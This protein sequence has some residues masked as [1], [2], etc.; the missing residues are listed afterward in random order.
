MLG[1]KD[2]KAVKPVASNTNLQITT[3]AGDGD[4]EDAL[5]VQIGDHVL[6]KRLADNSAEVT[7]GGDLII[8]LKTGKGSIKVA[9]QDIPAQ[10]AQSL[11]DTEQITNST[12]AAD[13]FDDKGELGVDALPVVTTQADPALMSDNQLLSDERA[14]DTSQDEVLPVVTSTIVEADALADDLTANNDQLQSTTTE[15]TAISPAISASDIKAQ[16]QPRR[17]LLDFRGFN[18]GSGKARDGSN[19]SKR[20]EDKNQQAQDV[21]VVT[22]TP[23]VPITVQVPQEILD[24]NGQPLLWTNRPLELVDLYQQGYFSDKTRLALRQVQRVFEGAGLS[25]IAP[26]S[27]VENASSL[28]LNFKGSPQVI[29]LYAAKNKPLPVSLVSNVTKSPLEVALKDA[30]GA[31][32]ARLEVGAGGISN[33]L[34]VHLEQ[35]ASESA[36]QPLGTSLEIATSKAQTLFAVGAIRTDSL[37]NSDTN[38]IATGR[39]QGQTSTKKIELGYFHLCLENTGNLLFVASRGDEAARASLA[40]CVLNIAAGRLISGNDD[41]TNFQICLVEPPTHLGSTPEQ[42]VQTLAREMAELGVEDATLRRV[43][44]R[45]IES[46][47]LT[48]KSLVTLPNVT[49]LIE[50]TGNPVTSSNTNIGS[51]DETHWK[52]RLLDLTGWLVEQLISRRNDMARQEQK[53]LLVLEDLNAALEACGDDLRQL[54]EEG[55]KHGIYTISATSY[56]ALATTNPTNAGPRLGDILAAFGTLGVFAALDE[57]ASVRV[58]G[59]NAAYRELGGYGDMFLRTI[60]NQQLRLGGFKTYARQIE[61]LATMSSTAETENNEVDAQ[62]EASS[63]DKGEN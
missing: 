12:A 59:N 20:G 31:A 51:D 57:Q 6:V 18:F 26:V 29:A 25:P 44:S 56:E 41:A 28:R 21:E 37:F 10:L 58:W 24:E 55:P 1:R 48:L 50:A 45:E 35:I 5:Q 46:G 42:L 60:N 11:S 36:Y 2:K 61:E 4:T 30:T 27:C 39:Q 62:S 19:K 40:S 16:S 33:S 14:A 34:S 63:K 13:G 53:I 32:A 22:V 15:I 43:L 3:I 9:G 47:W 49:A 7:I 54:L 8:S 38:D 52:E 23:L 17:K